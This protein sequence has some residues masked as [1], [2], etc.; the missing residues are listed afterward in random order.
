[1]KNLSYRSKTVLDTVEHAKAKSRETSK[2]GITVILQPKVQLYSGI[3][4][5]L[6]KIPDL[7]KK[8]LYRYS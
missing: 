8:S 3:P 6:L 2:Q 5:E 4:S 1:M 7:N